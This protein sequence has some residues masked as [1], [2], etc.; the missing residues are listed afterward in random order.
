MRPCPPD[1]LPILGRVPG[2]EGAYMACGHNCWGILW[3]P[4]TGKIV[5]EL[6]AS[7]G[8]RSAGVDID[9]F[10]PGR[11][12]RRKDERGKKMGFLSVGEQW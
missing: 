4:V 3:A 7:E 6:V 8:E 5:S 12:M 11:F 2:V 10:S 1:A 9:A